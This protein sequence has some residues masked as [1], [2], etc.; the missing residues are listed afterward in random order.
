MP[1]A[2][3][4]VAMRVTEWVKEPVSAPSMRRDM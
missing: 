1:K 4:T 2:M 3:L